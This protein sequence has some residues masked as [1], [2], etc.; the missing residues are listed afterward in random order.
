MAA[1]AGTATRVRRRTVLI[2]DDS[3]DVRT[4]VRFALADDPRFAVVGEASD[5]AA[6][7]EQARLLQP[8]VVLLDLAMPNVDGRRALPRLRAAL[9]NASLVVFTAHAQRFGSDDLE[10]RGADAVLV[11]TTSLATLRDELASLA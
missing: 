9:P 11:K 10:R 5:G 3:E 1:S 6:A 4:M 2:V 8:D 7:L